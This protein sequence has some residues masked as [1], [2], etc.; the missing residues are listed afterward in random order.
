MSRDRKWPTDK[1]GS[2]RIEIQNGK[3]RQDNDQRPVLLSRA[4]LRFLILVH[5]R[6]CAASVHLSF[7]VET[8][9]F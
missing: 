1:D 3:R 6:E 8:R 7:V 5:P 2:T 4:A 9:L